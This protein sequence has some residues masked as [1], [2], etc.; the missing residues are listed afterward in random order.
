MWGGMGRPYAAPGRR[1]RAIVLCSAV[2][3]KL[4][5]ASVPSPAAIW[6]RIKRIDCTRNARPADLARNTRSR[7]ESERQNACRLKISRTM[8]IAIILRSKKNDQLSM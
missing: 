5:G 2:C 1:C 7:H 4:T 8:V 3:A 6:L